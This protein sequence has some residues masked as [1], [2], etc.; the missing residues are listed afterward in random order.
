[1][2]KIFNKIKNDWVFLVGAAITMLKGVKK[3]LKRNFKR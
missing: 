3:S 2:I 1:M